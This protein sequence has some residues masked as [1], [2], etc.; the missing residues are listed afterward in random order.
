MY[1][2][3]YNTTAVG[4]NPY[5]L[6]NSQQPIAPIPQRREIDKV[7]G[8]NG[9]EMYAI[10]PDSSVLLLDLN[11]PIVWF[12]Q[13]DSAGYKTIIP[14]DIKPHEEEPAPDV[15]SIDERMNGFDERLR[16]IEEAL[17]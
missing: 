2:N 3:M 13:T 12:V 4:S 9:A 8:K 14:Y 10:A 17:K 7:N 16:I 15:K 1:P 6:F 5:G 11:N